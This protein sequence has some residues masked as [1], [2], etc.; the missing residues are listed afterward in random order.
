MFL[1][2]VRLRN[3]CQH[4][5]R[6]V[7]F[8][9]GLNVIVGPNGSGKSNILNA[10]YGALTGDF[11][12]NSGKAAENISLNSDGGES[13]VDLHFS[14]N[15][16]DLRLVRRLDPTDR[17][18]YV[19]DK[20]YTSDKEVAEKLL[21]ILEVDKEI[22]GQYVFVEQWDNFGP[23]ALSAA[24]RISAFQKLFKIEQLNKIGDNLSDGSLKLATV[25]V[26]ASSLQDLNA[27][28]IK[29][30]QAVVDLTTKLSTM[31]LE[32]DLDAE[33]LRNSDIVSL[34]DRKTKLENSVTSR[35]E[36]IKKL[37]K[38][39]QD[40][41]V[42]L[43]SLTDELLSLHDLIDQLEA[44]AEE[45]SK[46]EAL[47]VKY[48]NYLDQKKKAEK[49]LALIEAERLLNPEP[50]QPEDYLT[51]A[52]AV[53]LTLDSLKF[54]QKQ[55][56][57]FLSS[58]NPDD[59]S[60]SCPTCGTPAKNLKDKWLKA[61]DELTELSDS[62]T[63]LTSQ[64]AS[65]AL[66]DKKAALH[67]AWKVNFMRRKE[68]AERVLAEVSEVEQPSVSRDEAK[69]ILNKRKILKD[70]FIDVGNKI[71]VLDVS[72]GKIAVAL[73][74]QNAEMTKELNELTSYSDLDENSVN[75]SNTRISE[76]KAVKGSIQRLNTD[77]AL[78][79]AEVTN[80]KQRIA[81]ANEQ[82]RLASLHDSWN[83][84]VDNL[85]K[86][87]RYNALPMVLSYK[88][89]AKVVTELNDTLAQIGVPFNIEL[90]QDLSF[91]ANFGSKKVPA[92]RLSGGQKVI[93]TIAYRLAVNS[94]FASNLGLLCLDEPT[95]GLDEANLGAL[96]KA[97]DRLKQFSASNG[98]QILVVTHEKNI[99][100][101]FDHTIDLA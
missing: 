63:K 35:L 6:T 57:Q 55:H 44:S 40:H 90:E 54:K 20:V 1:K 70:S 16:Q 41:E 51:D 27:N 64:L 28:L 83:E 46:I 74:H 24:K 23:L 42:K 78:A 47:W 96:E 58:I 66:Y 18:L 13:G 10:V 49:A 87:F 100:H 15:S 97:F 7:E 101:L 81:T 82:V 86:V 29:A 61:K 34:W 62:I 77:I 11:G 17:Q 56:T 4:I 14:H 36:T 9:K 32:A 60:A 76:L 21:H 71:N 89:M 73:E 37:E 43:K 5:D 50:Q 19:N 3:F 91:T 95:V 85:K 52:E 59:D 53:A 93:L 8:Q 39:K 99:G 84:R 12:R 45:A 22:L 98:V 30:E 33:I 67:Q 48:D 94:T 31:P 69:E 79:E 88:Y 25:G 38:D 92:A 68:T 72:G 65:T 80:C 26:N 2:K 75:S